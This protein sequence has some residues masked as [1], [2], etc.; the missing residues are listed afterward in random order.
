MKLKE[1][2][3]TSQSIIL[4]QLGVELLDME[5][6]TIFQLIIFWWHASSDQQMRIIGH[7]YLFWAHTPGVN[8]CCNLHSDILLNEK[9]NFQGKI[10]K[11]CT[12]SISALN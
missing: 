4:D 3:E 8:I 11:Y 5:T 12:S 10:Y 6:E 9:R 7:R 1:L 2:G